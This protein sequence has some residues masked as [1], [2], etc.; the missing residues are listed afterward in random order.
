MLI[1]IIDAHKR[2]YV[3]VASVCGSVGHS[4]HIRG[5]ILEQIEQTAAGLVQMPERNKYLDGE[6][7][8]FREII[9]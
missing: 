6:T 5:A 1:S 9:F 7:E 8:L 3:S 2:R 4:G